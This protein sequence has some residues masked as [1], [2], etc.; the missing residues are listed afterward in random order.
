M[1][2]WVNGAQNKRQLQLICNITNPLQN[3]VRTNILG[4]NLS[5]FSQTASLPL[6]ETPSRIPYPPIS[7]SNFLWLNISNRTLET[8]ETLR[9]SQ[10]TFT[11]S[12]AWWTKSKTNISALQT[13]NHPIGEYIPP[14]IQCLKWSCSNARVVDI[15]THSLSLR[16][17]SV[18]SAL[19]SWE[20]S[21]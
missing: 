20:M 21:S 3:Q 15:C 17:Y 4:T 18:E 10:I 7:N 11:F 2:Y 8:L 5:P 6:W 16:A 12:K 13:S 14:T 19:N 1:E 9:L